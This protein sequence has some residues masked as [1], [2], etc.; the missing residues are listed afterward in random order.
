MMVNFQWARMLLLTRFFILAVALI[1]LA[2][3]AFAKKD[4]LP[5]LKTAIIGKWQETGGP[6]TIRFFEGGT[7]ILSG[8]EKS[9]T[10][11]YKVLDEEHLR[12]QPKFNARV[13]EDSARVVKF[14][15]L[16]GQLTISGLLP[17]TTRFQKQK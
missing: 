14:S 11:Y 12:I 3:C 13:S 5:G 15:I 17:K 1:L 7:M 16:R 2:S 8:K 10:A 6:T 4:K 9:M